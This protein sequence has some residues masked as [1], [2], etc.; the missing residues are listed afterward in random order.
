MR[1]LIVDDNA[2]TR[3]ILRKNLTDLGHEVF[4]ADN[5]MRAWDEFSA[6]DFPLVIT[7]LKMPGMDGIELLARIKASPNGRIADVII[8]TAHGD[9]DTALQ[10][11]RHGAYDYLAKPLNTT[12]LKSLIERAAEHQA[13]LRENRK[14]SRHLEE[15]VQ[16]VAHEIIDDLEATRNTLRKVTGIGEIITMSPCMLRL[17][18]ETRIF[19]ENRLVPVLIEGETGTGKEVIARLIHYGDKGTDTPMVSINCAAI[20]PDL[21]E[22]ELF[23]YAPGAFTGSARKGARGK[24]DLAGHGTLFLDEV[25]EMPLN[26]QP[27]LLR[28][29]ETRRYFRVGGT[30]QEEFNA[31]V[32]CATNRDLTRMVDS[33]AFRRDLFH[34]L[35]IG[36]LRIPPLRERREEI[37]PLARVFLAREAERKKKR[38]HD[39]SPEAQDLLTSRTWRGNV[40]ELENAIERAVLMADAAEL[41]PEHLGFLFEDMGAPLSAAG[42]REAPNMT[43]PTPQSLPEGSFN[44]DEHCNHIIRLVLEKFAGNKTRAAKYLGLSRSAFCRRVEKMNVEHKA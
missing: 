8:L 17:V 20:S 4:E 33:G 32:I 43:T 16:E 11:L 14:L 1:I 9:M 7:D 41:G 21:F 22:S 3:I 13:L 39:I 23:G 28:V 42:R 35:Q 38:F 31:R 36:H 37:I 2:T 44:L 25:G 30:R 12:E 5:G 27:K 24:L 6:N 29:L 15:R 40:R 10:A 19:H 18:E 34:R 26:L